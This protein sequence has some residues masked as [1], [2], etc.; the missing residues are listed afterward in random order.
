MYKLITF[1]LLIYLFFSCSEQT[2]SKEEGAKETSP[3]LSSTKSEDANKEVIEFWKLITKQEVDKA[4]NLANSL[5]K[6]NSG[7]VA[8]FFKDL[9]KKEAVKE[10]VLS[11]KAF[12]KVDAFFWTQAQYFKSKV[13]DAIA[14]NEDKED[15]KILY[16]LVVEKVKP[17]SEA[18]DVGSYPIHIWE[19]GFGACDRQSWAYCELIYQLGGNASII[20]LRNPDTLESPHTICEVVLNGKHYVVDILNKKFLAD[21]KYSDLSLEKIKEIWKEVPD[22]H[23]TFAK[24]VRLIPAMPID[25]SE[26]N[27]RLNARLGKHIKFGEPPQNRFHFWKKVYPKDDIRFWGYPI[28]IL[29]F[30]KFYKDEEK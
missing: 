10:T 13:N 30:T 8:G 9:F 5:V 12:N 15:A 6:E 1:S 24:H 21:T 19:R 20:Y 27:Q 2:K 7:E 25:Y 29:Q 16:D 23:N 17:Q 14:K 22:I 4:V 3:E 11:R 26:R 18:Q 28:R